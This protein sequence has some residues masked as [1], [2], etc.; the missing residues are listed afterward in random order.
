MKQFLYLVCLMIISIFSNYLQASDRIA[1]INLY[2]ILQKLPEKNNLI[3]KIDNEFKT[4]ANA[5]KLQEN[6]LRDKI[7]T[8]NRDKSIMKLTEK[9]HLENDI[10]KQQNLF[11]A[12]SQVFER[13]KRRRQVEE[14]NKILI[15]IQKAIKKVAKIH[16]YN[17]VI[18]SKAITYMSH[19]KNITK[20]VLKN[21]N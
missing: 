1:V 10:N 11:S 6:K 14:R 13:D 5:L 2:D 3:K 19:I 16:N 21:V 15:K 12:K 20:E 17:I 18:D 8:F 4:R 9:K 7:K